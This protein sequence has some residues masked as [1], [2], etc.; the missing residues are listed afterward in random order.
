MI[1]NN[2]TKKWL[3]NLRLFG[4]NSEI[5]CSREEKV[6]NQECV[7]TRHVNLAVKHM[8]NDFDF[9]YENDLNHQLVFEDGKQILLFSIGEEDYYTDISFIHELIVYPTNNYK[10]MQVS[11]CLPLTSIL[12]WYEG[13]IPVIYTDSLI[14]NEFYDKDYLII[15]DI[16][17]EIFAFTITNFYQ[18]FEIE[19]STYGK[20]IELSDKIFKFLDFC[21][22]EDLLIKLR[23]NIML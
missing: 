8:H 16:G 11:G 19:N 3:K 5:H 12:N 14:N 18:K 22:Y 15:Y 17:K 21:S 2:K 7:G 9:Q 6:L 10:E 20:S 13:L 23:M 4:I 1:D